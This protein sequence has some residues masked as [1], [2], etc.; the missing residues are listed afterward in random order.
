VGCAIQTCPDIVRRAN[1]ITY[2]SRNDSPSLILHGR[3]DVRVPSG[4]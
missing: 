1:P 4:T 3:R 2:A